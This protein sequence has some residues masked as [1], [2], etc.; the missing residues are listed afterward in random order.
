MN[1]HLSEEQKIKILNS[2]SMYKVMQEIL[3]REND[4]DR[5]KEHF[6]LACLSQSNKILLIEL[7]S[8]GSVHTT[9]V[10]PMDV[11]SF[12]LQKRAVKL[13]MVH[14]HPSG[15]LTPSENDMA[16]TEK[17]MAIG[18]FVQVPIIDHLIISETEYY[19]FA[20]N[21]LTDKMEKE[22]KFDLSF[23]KMDEALKQLKEK[24]TELKEVRDKMT[25]Q[26]AKKMISRGRYTIE[27][28]AELTGLTIK[29][30]EELKINYK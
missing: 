1:I 15:D 13:I 24:E 10:E 16:L 19:S 27:E 26:M 5:D 18:K 11:F 14:N 20:N 29:Q 2:A 22:E 4:I 23:K 6:W 30:V 25:T 21:G 3:L 9:V 17:M 7:I 8:L 28:I 12:A